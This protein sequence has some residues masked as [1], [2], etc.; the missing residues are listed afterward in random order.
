MRRMTR[1]IGVV[2]FAAT[3]AA[4]PGGA[5]AQRAAG[6]ALSV[7]G[8][9]QP[10]EAVPAALLLLVGLGIVISSAGDELE[11]GIAAD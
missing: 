6:D 5:V 9:T 11:P 10:V 3:A 4:V 8:L 1:L 2:V 7:P